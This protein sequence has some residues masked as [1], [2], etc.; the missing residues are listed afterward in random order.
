MPAHVQE[1]PQREARTGLGQP[2]IVILFN[3]DYHA[4]DAV[5]AQVQKAAGC[6]QAEAFQITY[7]A[8]TNGQAVAYIGTRPECER[9]ASVLREIDLRAEVEEP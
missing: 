7:A 8:H 9:V 1:T 5:V 4:F 6:G 3:D 2:W